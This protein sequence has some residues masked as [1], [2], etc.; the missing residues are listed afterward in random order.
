MDPVVG[1]AKEVGGEVH[2]GEVG[3]SVYM[4]EDMQLK[5][6]DGG[7]AYMGFWCLQV[8]VTVQDA[9]QST[10]HE[11]CWGWAVQSCVGVGACRMQCS[12]LG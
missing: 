3:V 4:G 9:V 10:G 1:R 7:H 2:M 12:M 11:R 6:S 5:S 8:V